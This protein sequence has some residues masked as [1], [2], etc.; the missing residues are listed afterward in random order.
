VIRLAVVAVVALVATPW[1]GFRILL[2]SWLG[3]RKSD[4]VCREEPRRWCSWLLR[5]AGVR[6]A[7][8][9][10]EHLEGS[11]GQILV[12]NHVSWFDVLVLAAHLPVEYRFIAKK[13]L[14]NVPIFGP[15][16][17]ACGHISIDRDD[18]ASAIRSLDEAGRQIRDDDVT[19]ILFPEGTRSPTG[20]LL[21]FKKGAFVLAIQ[22]GVRVVP[23]A[24]SG[25]RRV[26]RKGSW[27]IRS[28]TIRVRFGEP[29]DVEGYGEKDRGRLTA[30]ARARISTMLEDAAGRDPADP[31]RVDRGGRRAPEGHPR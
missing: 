13:E 29:I 15:A 1:Y 11:E 5:A 22:A 17:Q 27:W 4:R 21:P 3:T 26:M 2:H 25:S 18:R 24:I 31:P 23:A 14:E 28:G 30:L 6:V 19:V 9:G 20:A 8:E 10:T 12:A 7:L 16:W